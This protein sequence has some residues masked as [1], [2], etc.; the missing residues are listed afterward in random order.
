MVQIAPIARAQSRF[1][2]QYVVPGAQSLTRATFVRAGPENRSPG[3]LAGATGADGW[4]GQDF[5][6]VA[7]PYHRDRRA[8]ILCKRYGLTATM[9]DTVAGL[10]WGAGA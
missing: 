5:S 2:A 10:A 8:A 4:S 9:A 1:A 6:R 7:A 3:A